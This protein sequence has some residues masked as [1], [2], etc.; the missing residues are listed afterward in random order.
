MLPASSFLAKSRPLDAEV[1]SSMRKPS[2]LLPILLLLH[3]AVPVERAHATVYG[4]IQGIV[5]DPHHRPIP[6]AKVEL[7]SID[8]S[9]VQVLEADRDGAF[10]FQI[11]SFGDY[12]L[13]VSA[14]R[15]RL[16]NTKGHTRLGNFTDAP[17]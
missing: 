2:F 15:L 4:Q 8:S 13:T 10:R 6:G 3:L 14:T 11:V 12:T 7:K 16:S 5:H 9:A 1:D 17:L